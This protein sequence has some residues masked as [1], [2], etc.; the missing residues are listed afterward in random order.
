ME[1]GSGFEILMEKP[2]LEIIDSE[3]T[4]FLL[5]PSFPELQ[6]QRGWNLLIE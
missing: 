4:L 3:A 6:T 5:I 2:A 1:K